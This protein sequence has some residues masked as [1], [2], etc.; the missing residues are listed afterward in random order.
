[1]SQVHLVDYEKPELVDPLVRAIHAATPLGAVISLTEPGLIPAARFAALLGLP[2]NSLACVTLLK[3]KWRMRQRLAEVGLSPVA[4]RP[5]RTQA[6]IEAFVAEVGKP[7]IVKPVDGAGSFAIFRAARPA[8]AAGIAAELTRLGVEAFLMEEQIAGH[9][10]SVEGFS[11]AG[12]HVILAIT[13]KLTGQNFVEIGHSMPA[14]LARGIREQIV[15]LVGGFL[16]AVGL[17]DGPSHTELKLSPDGPRIIEGHNRIGG[18]RINELVRVVYGVDMVTL[19]FAWAFG[20]AAP[21]PRPPVALR[22]AAIRYLV[23]PPGLVQRLGGVEEARVRRDVIEL[24]IT[25]RVGERIRPLAYSPDRAGHVLAQG[26]SVDEAIAAC[27]AALAAL[28]LEVVAEA[29]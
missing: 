13:D 27:E 23:P 16:D 7:I 29:A 1:V 14:R 2:H 10:I 3:D 9:E 6:D 17:T 15:E 24:E 28:A 20:L 8:D 19:T 21:L 26:T 22:C 18:D 11:F 12:R 4:A 25:T 5:G